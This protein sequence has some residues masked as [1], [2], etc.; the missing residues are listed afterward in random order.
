MVD[1]RRLC[2][3]H[4]IGGISAEAGTRKA[5]HLPKAD[6]QNGIRDVSRK[7]LVQS[8]TGSTGAKGAGVLNLILA[9]GRGRLTQILIANIRD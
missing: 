6:P 4:S 1:G 8:P 2:T 5:N 7:A 9:L 3:G